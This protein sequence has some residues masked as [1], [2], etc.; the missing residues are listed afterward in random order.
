MQEV[1][2]RVSAVCAHMESENVTPKLDKH[3]ND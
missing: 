2:W 1:W 3:E